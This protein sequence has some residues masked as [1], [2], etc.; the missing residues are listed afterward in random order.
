MWFE[1]CRVPV[2]PS[3]K[4]IM[5]YLFL[6]IVILL[7]ACTATQVNQSISTANTILTDGSTSKAPTTDEV[8]AGLKEALINGIS[9][10]ADLTSQTDGFFK[11]PAIMI[12]FP[13]DVK[14]VEESLRQIGMGSQVDKFVMTLNRGAEEAAKE[15]KPIFISAIKQMTIQDAWG[16]LKGEPNAATEFL[17]RTTSA[18]LKEKFTP[19][20]Q[21]SLNKVDA[22]KYYG[23]LVNTYNQIPLVQKVNPDLTN[24]ATDLAMQGLFT[25]IAQE[26]KNIRQNPAARTTELLKKVFGV[27]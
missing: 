11:N 22:T 18:Q 10:G 3:I 1:F 7:S 8:G 17:K 9:K 20:I 2:Q 27:K 5:K 13:P 12:P 26:E 14:R 4:V 21:N 19:V 6:P 24:Y 15:A 16:I 23:N 25:M